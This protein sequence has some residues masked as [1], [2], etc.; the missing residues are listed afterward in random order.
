MNNIFND[1][2]YSVENAEELISPQ[3]IYYKDL[4]EDNLDQIIKM[5]GGS[6]KLWPHVKT[7]KSLDMVKLQISKGIRRFKCAQLAEVEM[8]CMAGAEAA[9]LSMAPTGKVPERMLMLQKTYPDTQ[10]FGII[11]CDYHLEMYA[12]TAKKHN[13]IFNLLLDVNMGMNRTGIPTAEAGGFYQK[14][15]LVPGIKLWGFHCYDGNRHEIDLSERQKLVDHD[16]EAVFELKQQLQEKGVPVPYIIFGGSP[17][18]PCHL[19]YKDDGIYYSL[20]TSF[21]NDIGYSRNFPDLTMKPAAAV[22]CHVISHPAPGIFTLDL[23]YKGIAG[24]PPMEK[25]GTI[26]GLDHY[27]AVMQNEEH[28]VFRMEN[29]FENLRPAVG[30]VL[31][32]I[33]FHVCPCAM[34][35]PSIMI[36]NGGKIVDEWPVTARDRKINY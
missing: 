6:S 26:I 1:Y 17:S 19:K 21:V 3:L 13:A 32:V 16:D 11:D 25:R 27:E 24:D 5:A 22:L 30:T 34:L 23:G 8:V 9:V 33:P 28:Y 20:G 15:C 36:A 18:F 7:H 29:G 2:D 35:Y 14:A 12:D 10:I 4:F 31:Y